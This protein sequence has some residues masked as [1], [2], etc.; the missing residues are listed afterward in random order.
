M[1]EVYRFL[2]ERDSH[3]SESGSAHG[4]KYSLEGGIMR[5]VTLGVSSIEDTR[6]QMAA[7]FGGERVERGRV[8][9]PYGAVHVDFT[10]R[11]AA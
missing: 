2:Y 4:I 1:R 11:M 10:L 7:A 5:T 3:P 6:G 9:F 8:I